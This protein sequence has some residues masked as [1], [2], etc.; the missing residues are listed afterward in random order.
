MSEVSPSAGGTP[1]RQ[2]HPVE[3]AYYEAS[4]G[5]AALAR[6]TKGHEAMIN[7]DA[8]L[9]EIARIKASLDTLEVL[10][11]E[12]KAKRDAVKAD[13]AAAQAEADKAAR[14]EAQ[15]LERNARRRKAPVAETPVEVEPEPAPVSNV[16]EM[17]IPIRQVKPKG[18]I[19]R[20]L[21]S[22]AR[23]S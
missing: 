17:S 21:G 18:L 10:C 23:A 20:A 7:P 4:Y 8:A 13:K 5:M 3:R 14:L 15:R 11:V 19:K 22:F 6:S 9:S 2:S 1:P 12:E 16:I